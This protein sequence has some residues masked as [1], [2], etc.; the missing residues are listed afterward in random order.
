MKEVLCNDVI[1]DNVK[2]KLVTAGYDISDITIKSIIETYNKEVCN[3]I[4]GGKT[5]DLGG[6]TV[7]AKL[8][9]TNRVFETRGYTV[10]LSATLDKQM[11]KTMLD[12][13]EANT[14]NFE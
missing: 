13:Y 14:I 6:F 8:R 2:D 3:A 1:Y 10:K 11:K 4:S 9:K 12:L 5:V 7:M